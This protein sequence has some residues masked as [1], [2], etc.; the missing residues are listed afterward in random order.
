LGRKP[1]RINETIILFIKM[2]TKMII[3][4]MDEFVLL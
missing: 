1:V 2:Q 4:F 3:L